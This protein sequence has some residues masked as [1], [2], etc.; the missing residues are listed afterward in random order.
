M[1][2]FLTQDFI[3]LAKS[4]Y[5]LTYLDYLKQ[6]H[7]EVLHLWQQSELPDEF[8]LQS[9]DLFVLPNLID[10]LSAQLEQHLNLD[11]QVAYIQYCARANL[12]KAF[13]SIEL[14]SGHT[15]RE[16]LKDYLDR[17][18]FESTTLNHRFLHQLGSTWLVRDKPFK[19]ENW[20]RMSDA[21]MVE[22]WTLLIQKLTG[23]YWYPKKIWVQSDA[24]RYIQKMWADRSF[25]LFA[26]REITGIELPEALLDLKPQMM[27]VRDINQQTQPELF[28]LKTTLK[29]S[30]KPYLIN[31]RPSINTA[32]NI[33]GFHPRQLQRKLYKEN[34]KYTKVLDELIFDNVK[35]EL[36]ETEDE[37]ADIAFRHGYRLQT[38][39]TRAFKK[40]C[41]LT[42]SEF[43]HQQRD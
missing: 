20:L 14:M 22:F 19:D 1:T 40:Y 29:L 30:L 23:T 10:R 24:S 8:T 33:L 3:Q 17:A 9:S 38:H 26:H 13:E 12:K 21:Y 34:L 2:D 11:Q 41:K 27:P 36:V 39:F 35:E 6:H 42:P 43:R 7:P 32:A 18:I 37:I 4:K 25:E 15:L 31:G 28:D 5:L 16:Q